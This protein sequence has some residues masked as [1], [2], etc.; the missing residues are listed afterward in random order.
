[1][2]KIA[3]IVIIM[4]ISICVHA[5]CNKTVNWVGSKTEYLD[6]SE[7]IQNTQNAPIMVQTTINHITVTFK[8][9]D[10]QSDVIEGDITD[11]NCNWDEP[12]KNGKTNF[13]SVMAKSNGETRDAIVYIEGKDGK[14]TITI[15]LENMNGLQMRI[16]VDSYSE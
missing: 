11:L 16:P 8:T 6:S 14:I 10:G 13:K 12:F 3:A 1:M 5:Q 2:K 9:N 15:K 4:A 7:V